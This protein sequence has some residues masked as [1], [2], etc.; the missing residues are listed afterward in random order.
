MSSR[1]S[2]SSFAVLVD[3]ADVVAAISVIVSSSI[4]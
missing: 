3:I 2:A 4:V 1:S